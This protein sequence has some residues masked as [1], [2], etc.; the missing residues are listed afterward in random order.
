MNL[1]EQVDTLK[2]QASQDSASIYELRTCL[3][4]EKEG[5]FLPY[6]WQDL[7]S[8]TCVKLQTEQMW[9][10]QTFSCDSFTILAPNV[11]FTTTCQATTNSHWA[12]YVLCKNS[13]LFVQMLSLKSCSFWWSSS[14]SNRGDRSSKEPCR[15]TPTTPCR[16]KCS[17]RLTRQ[18]LK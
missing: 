2:V 7:P 9:I 13:C 16:G 6:L 4:Q 14:R 11:L 15:P 18:L 12:W 17:R 8:V 1:Q 5:E 10:I 3:E